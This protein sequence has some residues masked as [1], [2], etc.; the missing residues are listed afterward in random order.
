MQLSSSLWM[1]SQFITCM[2]LER[3]GRQVHFLW[4]QCHYRFRIRS[5]IDHL[6]GCRCLISRLERWLRG[7]HGGAVHDTL[8]EYDD[9][10]ATK[11]LKHSLRRL[12]KQSVNRIWKKELF[13]ICHYISDFFFSKLNSIYSRDEI[14]TNKIRSKT[15][16]SKSKK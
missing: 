13:T 11:L 6:V 15:K 12:S 1:P 3:N 9:R 8:L 5:G 4:R 14:K 10:L 2:I 16:I 7:Q